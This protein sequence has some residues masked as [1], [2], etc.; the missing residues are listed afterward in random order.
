VFYH[1]ILINE[2]NLECRYCLG[3]AFDNTEGWPEELELDESVPLKLSYPLEDL[4]AF[5]AK[6]PEPVLSFYGGEALLAQD[7]LKAIMDKVKAKH[8]IMQTN[9]LLLHQLEPEYLNRLH[10]I[11]VSLDGDEKTTDYFRGKGTYRKVMDNLNIIKRNGFQG[12]LIARMAV[13]EPNDLHQSVKHL[14]ENDDFSFTSIHWQLDMEFDNDFHSR[15]FLPWI[16]KS[17]NPGLEKLLSFWLEEMEENA[18]VLRLYPFLGVMH[19]LLHHEKSRLRC[20]SGYA[21][22]SIQT[23][24]KI[25]PCPIMA[26]IKSYYLGHIKSSDPNNL[27]QVSCGPPCPECD[28]LDLC[29]GRCFFANVSKLWG[30]EKRHACNTVRF[31]LKIMQ[32]AQPKIEGLIEAGKL[33]L[34]DFDYVKY[35]GA[36]IIP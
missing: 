21:N 35:N 25:I 10:T 7:K 17:Y 15:D 2:C 14:L 33:S 11:L 3:K 9:G 20:G 16:E 12:E 32:E 13:S 5:I 31:F 1:L 19:S 6:D 23:D 30:E 36:E 8:F 28:L 26:G 4:K 34:K 18:R 22:Y 29:G 27:P 24:G